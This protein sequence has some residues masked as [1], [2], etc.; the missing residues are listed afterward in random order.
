MCGLSDERDDWQLTCRHYRQWLWRVQ[1]WWVPQY[2][3]TCRRSC[4]VCTAVLRNIMRCSPA[5]ES[6]SS[7]TSY[8]NLWRLDCLSLINTH[9]RSLA[10]STWTRS[11]S[12]TPLVSSVLQPQLSHRPHTVTGPSASHLTLIFHSITQIVC[13]SFTCSSH[14]ISRKSSSASKLKIPPQK[15]QQMVFSARKWEWD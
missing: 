9:A 7:S 14:P 12:S 3:A 2:S 8:R 6:S 4:C 13:I 15:M 5:F 10:A 1:L 11:V